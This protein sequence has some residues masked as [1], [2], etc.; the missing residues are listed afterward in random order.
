MSAI[1]AQE[2]RAHLALKG[3]HPADAWLNSFLST[4]STAVPVSSLK[5]T[6]MYRVLHSDISTT[7][8]T[9]PSAVFPPNILDASIV[10]RKLPGIIP[11][12]V[13][14]IE[15][16]GRSKWSQV[17]ALES[18]ERGEMTKGREIIRVVPGEDEGTEP[19]SQLSS[20]GPHKVLLQDAAGCRVY[21]FELSSVPGVNLNI[22]IGAKLALK[23]VT[24]ARGVVL[25]QP[26][27]AT[28]LGGRID[29]LHKRWK[30]ELKEKL[31]NAAQSTQSTT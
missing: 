31:K 8:Q 27:T 5:Q 24:V 23:D 1:A 26:T 22:A 13:M 10:E 19:P 15:D 16:I 6:A 11:V 28:L 20:A 12:Q 21:G 4:Q 18:V 2:I 17:E 14:D 30:E 9:G 29:E 25:L 3:L 7:L